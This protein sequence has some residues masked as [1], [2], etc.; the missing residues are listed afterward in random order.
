MKT[1]KPKA[2]NLAKAT[3]RK[4]GAGKAA[5]TKAMKAKAARQ[6]AKAKMTEE[7]IAHLNRQIPPE[8]HTA[9]YVW[10]KYWSRKT[11]NV[12]G[13]FIKTYSK[14]GEVV[15]DPFAG[16]GVVAIEAVRHGRRAIIC[17]LNPVATMIT[18]VTLRPVDLIAFKKAYERVKASVKKKMEALYEIHCVKCNKTLVG[19]CF[20]RVE[21]EL[22]EVRYQKCPHCGHRCESSAPTYE[23]VNRLQ[24]QEKKPLVGWYPND[25]LYYA[26]GNPFQEKQRYETLGDLFTRRNLQALIWLHEAIQQEPVP[27]VRKFL[28]AG[29]TSM[30]HLCTRMMPVGN[31]QETNHYTFF[32]SPGWTQHSYWSAQRYMEQP[33]WDKF[34]SAIVGSQGLFKAKEESH[35]ELP[36]VK[37]TTDWKK[38]INGES[39]VAIVTGDCLELMKAM[40]ESCVDYI[41]TDPPYDK[42]VQYGELSLLWNAWLKKAA[43]YTE[44]LTTYEIVHNDG[45]GKPFEV[46]HRLLSDSFNKAHRVL[47]SDRYLTLTFHNPTFKVRNAT[48]RA[49]VYA[50]FD[51]EKIHHQPLG[52][53]SAKSMIQPFGSAQGDFYLRFHKPVVKGSHPLEE[54]TEERFRRFVIE[55]CREVIAERAEPTP[56]TILINYVDPKL[57]KYGFFGTLHTGLDVKTV[58][59]EAVGTE[60]KLVPSKIGSV[61]GML[62]WFNDPV[63]VARLKEVPLTERVEQTVLRALNEKG[64]VTFTE[65]WDAVSRQFPNS[66]TSDSTSIKE[67]LEIYA[68]KV[69]PGYWMLREDVKQRVRSHSEMIALLARIGAK[70]GYDIWIGKPEQGAIAEGLGDG[71]QL[72][73]LVTIQPKS[74]VGVKNLKDVLLMDL[75]WFK[76]TEVVCAFEVES[77]TTMTSALQR[78]SNLPADTA[79]VMVL[80]EERKTDFDRK[81]QAPL[82]HEYYVKDGWRLLYFDRLREEFSKAKETTAIHTIFDLPSGTKKAAAAGT[83][84]SYLPF[85]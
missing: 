19:D 3:R 44:K 32:S 18:E 35:R 81:M 8:A 1:A 29:F 14:P 47:R 7:P 75:L 33:V 43:N 31:P 77:T 16:S 40:P 46:Y 22:T 67:A 27:L 28:M 23:D 72:A 12:V 68:R 24:K 53:V 15:L 52:Q 45:Q 20:V 78:G 69:G 26:N 82:F 54:I 2:R 11:W 21:D 34:E 70:R 51:Y 17:D 42:S 62:W 74:V 37:I 59:E 60:F 48:V 13:E 66:L 65:V 79:R 50:G 10:H 76:G 6:K 39:D 55:T 57:A 83:E 25:K 71:V 49:G 9:M 5:D 56:Y 73:S 38:V 64:R 80:P 61:S 36:K 4:T 41:F 58:L 84:Q 63:F 30:L 85:E